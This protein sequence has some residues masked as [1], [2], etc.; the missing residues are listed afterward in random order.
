MTINML[1]CGDALSSGRQRG[2]VAAFLSAGNGYLGVTAAHIFQYSG[3]DL[4]EVGGVKTR[5]SSLRREYDLAYFRVPQAKA[6]LLC[7]PE[8]GEAEVSSRLGIRRCRVSDISWSLCMIV[9]SPG[10]MPGPGESGAPVVQG[11]RVVGMLSSINLNTC[12][13]TMISSELM[14]REAGA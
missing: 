4:L 1:Q 12:K 11:G 14:A 10:D 7:P 9:L 3:S 5:V 6:T 2:T 8:F 13:G